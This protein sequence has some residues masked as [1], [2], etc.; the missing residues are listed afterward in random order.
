MLLN[1]EDFLFIILFCRILFLIKLIFRKGLGTQEKTFCSGWGRGRELNS[2]QKDSQEG[3][4]GSK[5]ANTDKS[6]NG[7]WS[8]LTFSCWAGPG[9][10]IALVTDL[11][12]LVIHQAL[13]IYWWQEG[14]FLTS[15]STAPCRTVLY[16]PVPFC[17]FLLNYLPETSAGAVTPRSS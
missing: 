13:I 17:T 16:C 11:Q 14:S 6:Q 4:G 7:H 2:K 9:L 3:S 15:S 5:I 1:R 12:W 10:A 8:R